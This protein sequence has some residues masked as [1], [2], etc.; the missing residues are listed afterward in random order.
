MSYKVEA[1][2]TIRRVG[3]ASRKQVLMYLANKASDD[4]SGVWCSK[5]T[6]ARETE[7]SDATVKRI[8]AEFVGVGL[9]VEE[10]RRRCVSGYTIIYRIDLDAVLDLPCLNG[11][12]GSGPQ[13]G[14]AKSGVKS[15]PD[16]AANAGRTGVDRPGSGVENGGGGGSQ[17]TGFTMTPV[18]HDPR[19]GVMVNPPGGH[20]E[21][22]TILKQPINNPCAGARA[23]DANFERFWAVHPKPTGKARSRALFDQAVAGGS[24]PDRI[25]EAA[26]AYARSCAE[27]TATTFVASSVNWLRDHRWSDKPAGPPDGGLRLVADAIRA[28]KRLPPS[29]LTYGQITRMI[30]LGMVSGDEL[31]RAGFQVACSVPVARVG[32]G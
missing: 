14:A 32:S 9:L 19:G 22:Q 18:H 2:V 20:G 8:M 28:G 30:D 4:G 10:G 12:D 3:S 31:V 1:L 24:D 11:S 27:R 26:R 5:G 15:G 13:D 25:V 17:C 21:P 29:C 16:R 6:I 7:L 23:A